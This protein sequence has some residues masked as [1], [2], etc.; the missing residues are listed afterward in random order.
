MLAHFRAFSRTL[1]HFGAL[2][3]TLA[4]CDAVW[5]S[6][7]HVGALWRTLT[8]T[9]RQTDKQT[10]TGRETGRQADRQRGRQ[11]G[12]LW[13]VLCRGCSPARFGAGP[14]KVGWQ[15]RETLRHKVVFCYVLQQSK[16]R[17]RSC[18]AMSCD[19]A[20]HEVHTLW[21]SGW[22]AGWLA[23]WLAGWQLAGSA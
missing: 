7:A 23:S 6:L 16:T 14:H 11:I 19:R 12:A 15:G 17:G 13:R 8:Q 5:R 9:D 2:W 22:L 20:K 10:Q 3:R 4:H 18:F 21:L 1:A